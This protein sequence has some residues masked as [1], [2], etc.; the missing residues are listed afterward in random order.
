MLIEELIR[1]GRPLIEGGLDPEEI[2][3]LVTDVETEQ[4]RDFYRHIFLVELP[5]NGAEKS[6][7]VH[8]MMVWLDELEV[9]E[10]KPVKR[11]SRPKRGRIGEQ[12]REGKGEKKFRLDPRAILAPFVYPLTGDKLVAQGRYGIA[13]YPCFESQLGSS[14]KPD[15]RREDRFRISPDIVTRF[16]RSR[17]D[18]T[19]QLQVPDDWMQQIAQDLHK[20]V[21]ALEE[22]KGDV[23]KGLVILVQAHESTSPFLYAEQRSRYSIIESKLQPGQWI[24]ARLSVMLNRT[25][26][27]KLAEAREQGERQGLCDL[28]AENDQLVSPYCK[29]WPWL[30]LEWAC[31]LPRAGSSELLIDGMGLS[32]ATYSALTAGACV[33]RRLTRRVHTFVLRELFA[34]VEN[35]DRQNSARG[36][37]DRDFPRIYGSAF[38]L[39]VQDQFLSSGEGRPVFAEG[40]RAMLRP[41]TDE[42]SLAERHLDAVIGFDAFLP[43]EFDREDFRLT[44]VYFSGE[45]T[46]GDIHLRACIQDVLPTTAKQLRD[47]ARQVADEAVEL[48]RRIIASASERQEAYIRRCYR[49]VP[50]LLARAYGGSHLWSELE[51]VLH[52]RPL[53]LR[54]ITANAAARMDSL[55][56][57][58]PDSRF[59]IFDEVL[60]YLSALNFVCRCNEMLARQQGDNRMS[61]RPWPEL[62]A[63]IEEGPIE[64]LHFCPDDPS[65]LGFVCGVLVRQFSRWYWM[66]TRVGNEGKDYLRHRVLTF[67]SDLSP[68]DVRF[69]ALA[70][71]FDLSRRVSGLFMPPDFER[72]TGVVIHELDNREQQVRNQRDSFMAAFWAGYALQGANRSQSVSPTPEVITGAQQ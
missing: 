27:A 58:F 15:K 69:R 30:T 50:Y 42:G 49:S 18:A 26:E 17:I 55:V 51:R 10:T 40:V 9:K 13:I 11:P 38:L 36:R 72:R 21:K 59:E 28:S 32:G 4:C 48:L 53:D 8:P 22:R 60:F 41:H 46:R 43:E 35:R 45:P 37:K 61:M 65:E 54:R 33:F 24:D 67:G 16:L 1:M 52:R 44:L 2:L 62:L 29:A 31:P 7:I 56:P 66:A 23:L 47:I 5:P 63:M 70:Q 25:W 14:A 39:P 68:R 71:M 19:D 3:R 57:R 34:P 20:E 6:P 12:A 64:N